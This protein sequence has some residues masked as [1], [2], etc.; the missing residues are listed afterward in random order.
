MIPDLPYH[1]LQ[2]Q[3][4]EICRRLRRQEWDLYKMPPPKPAEQQAG[5]LAPEAPKSLREEDGMQKKL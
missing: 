1:E 5:N 4:A 2:A 3:Q